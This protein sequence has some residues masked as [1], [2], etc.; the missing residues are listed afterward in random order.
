MTAV[1]APSIRRARPADLPVVA[2]ALSEAFLQGD[3]APW[4]V[5]PI[6]DR[7]RIYPP[8]FTMLAR[9]ALDHGHVEITDDE[10]AV[11]LWYD[12]EQAHIKIPD[13]TAQLA[14]ITAPYTA[15]FVAL[16]DAMDRHHP[17]QPHHHYLAFLAVHPVRHGRGYGSRLLQHHHQQLDASGVPAYL[18][19][20]GARNRA[21]YARHGYVTQ[22]AYALSRTGPLLFP[23]WRTPRT[24]APASPA[25]GPERHRPHPRPAAP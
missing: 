11:A 18:E 13:Y 14:Q 15:R 10:I 9:H 20:T 2:A 4:L 16:D 24:P 19:A 23:M 25:A 21:L 6:E 3:L 22:L 1:A 8:Y 17:Q 7:E 5:N 12:S